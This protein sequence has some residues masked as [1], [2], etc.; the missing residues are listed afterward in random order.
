MAAAAEKQDLPV[1][2]V[3][4]PGTTQA[5]L[6]CQCQCLHCTPVDTK[7]VRVLP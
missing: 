2:E 1:G 4:Q 6:D 5:R 7:I 3:G